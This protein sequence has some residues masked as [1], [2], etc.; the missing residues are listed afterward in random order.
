[1][2]EPTEAW[3]D[4]AMSAQILGFE[5]QDPE[6]WP[7]CVS[8]KYLDPSDMEVIVDIRYVSIDNLKEHA[9]L[10]NG[11]VSWLEAVK[12]HGARKAIEVTQLEVQAQA[13]DM[14]GLTVQD[15]LD[16]DGD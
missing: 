15:I 10:L 12:E 13:P 9:R 3:Y 4:V 1:M 16:A 7:D 11:A 14:T 2:S 6:E 8:V 5:D